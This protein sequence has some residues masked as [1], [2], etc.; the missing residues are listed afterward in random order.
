MKRK[1]FKNILEQRRD[2][3]LSLL[4]TCLKCNKWQDIVEGQKCYKKGLPNNIKQGTI[5][6]NC[7]HCIGLCYNLNAV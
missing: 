2:G 1:R 3:C 4:D 7:L 6:M 5:Q